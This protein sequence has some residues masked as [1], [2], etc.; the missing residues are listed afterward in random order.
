[1]EDFLASQGCQPVGTCVD[2]ETTT[3]QYGLAQLRKENIDA[4]N[5]C[6]LEGANGPVLAL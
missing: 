3:D 4:P 1:M 2:S 5:R 6:L